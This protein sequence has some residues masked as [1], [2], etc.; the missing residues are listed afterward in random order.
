M[1]EDVFGSIEVDA[2]LWV[3]L[4]DMLQTSLALLPHVSAKPVLLFPST[5]MTAE[6][7]RRLKAAA[8]T[9]FGAD[10]EEAA[11]ALLHAVQKG[12]WP[13]MGEG[14]AYHLTIAIDQTVRFLELCF[15]SQSPKPV[16]VFVSSAD[17]L[18]QLALW[19]YIR[20]W[21]DTGI[22]RWLEDIS[23]DE[24]VFYRFFARPHNDT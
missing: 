21:L 15:V 2:S 3:A 22:Y 23:R 5:P 12:E 8:I 6:S 17:N 11:R 10:T 20:W 13:P 7:T 18:A 9:A 14:A 16:S 1:F 24:A 4:R 19:F